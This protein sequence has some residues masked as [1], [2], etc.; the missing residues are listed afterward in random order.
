MK[1]LLRRNGSTL[2]I[3]CWAVGK[4]MKDGTSHTL[5]ITD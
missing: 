1:R 3:L 2:S 5:M 4:K